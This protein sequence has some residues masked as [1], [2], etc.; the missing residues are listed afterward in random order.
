MVKRYGADERF[1]DWLAN[2]PI[3]LPT[4]ASIKKVLSGN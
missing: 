3:L 4:I 1:R 2:T